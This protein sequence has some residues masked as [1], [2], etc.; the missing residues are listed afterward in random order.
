VRCA[1][2]RYFRNKKREYLK[3]TINELAMNS[4][5]KNIRELYRGI[6]EEWCLL[7]CY[8]VWLL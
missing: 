4:K 2:S 8:A 7:G 6:T 3:D 5:Y 1:E